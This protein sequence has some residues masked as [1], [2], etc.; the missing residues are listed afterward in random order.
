MMDKSSRVL[1]ASGGNE[2]V[3]D[4]G[5]K[6]HS[7]FAQVFIEALKNPIERVFTAEELLVHQIKESVAGRANQTP[8]YKIRRNS[9]HEGGDFVFVKKR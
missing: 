1:I 7:I 4:A 2:P 5:G 3:A 9:G 6:G 8:E